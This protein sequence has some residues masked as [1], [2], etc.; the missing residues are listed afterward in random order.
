ME[1]ME[2]WMPS[3]SESMPCR[4]RAI[5][6]GQENKGRIKMMFIPGGQG[7]PLSSKCGIY[8]TVK[9][10]FWPWLKLPLAFR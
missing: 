3:A 6:L 9:A 10:R 4:K 1:E 7:M 5:D 2:R 8:T